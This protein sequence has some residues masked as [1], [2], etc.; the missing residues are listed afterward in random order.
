MDEKQI[1]PKELWY[2]VQHDIYGDRKWLL[3]KKDV[4]NVIVNYP[5]KDFMALEEILKMVGIVV[6]LNVLI[7]RMIINCKWIKRSHWRKLK[8]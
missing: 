2:E 6:I 7:L 3:R 4:L 5:W 8:L 1:S